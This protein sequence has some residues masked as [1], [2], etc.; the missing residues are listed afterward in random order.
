[1]RV[2]GTGTRAGG[3]MEDDDGVTLCPVRYA[4]RSVE[5]ALSCTP[6]HLLLT[7]C[8]SRGGNGQWMGGDLNDDIKLCPECPIIPQRT[9]QFRAASVPGTVSPVMS[10]CHTLRRGACWLV[11][12]RTQEPLCQ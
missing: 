7:F 5:L 4:V 2:L 3:F 10:L 12:S 11:I 6:I 1:M 8:P 9:E